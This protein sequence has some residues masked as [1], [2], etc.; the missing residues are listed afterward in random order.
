MWNWVINTALISF[1]LSSFWLFKYNF[2]IKKKYPSYEYQIR[3]LI[4]SG[5]LSAV[6]FIVALNVYHQVY[7]LVEYK[8]LVRAMIGSSLIGLAAACAVY[9]LFTAL[10]WNNKK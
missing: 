5:L 3:K 2:G 6:S 1:F 4:T 7:N 10:F 9:M 8:F